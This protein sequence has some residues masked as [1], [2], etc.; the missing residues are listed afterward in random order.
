MKKTIIFYCIIFILFAAF[1]A[2]AQG[3]TSSQITVT[4]VP[5]AAAAL[6]HFLF[7]SITPIQ[8]IT[9]IYLAAKILRKAIPDKVQA[10]QFGVWL[11]HVA[12]EVNP[13]TNKLAADVPIAAP[14]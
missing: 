13:S 6:L 4:D 14:K 8:A 11:A 12:L 1:H 5:S 3:I 7:P 10:S 9:A 2:A